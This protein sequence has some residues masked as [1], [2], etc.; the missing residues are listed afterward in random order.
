[1]EEEVENVRVSPLASI[2]KKTKGE[3]TKE[4]SDD[5]GGLATER[6]SQH[7]TLGELRSFLFDQEDGCPADADL[8]RHIA[9][10]SECDTRI[11]HL[12]AVERYRRERTPTA[13]E[14]SAK[15]KY[16]HTETASPLRILKPV[17]FTAGAPPQ[18]QPISRVTSSPQS[19]EIAELQFESERFTN[20]L[21]QLLAS[22]PVWDTL[23]QWNDEIRTDELDANERARRVADVART[24]ERQLRR[25][26][27]TLREGIEATAA[28]LFN[29]MSAVSVT[30]AVQEQRIRSLVHSLSSEEQ[31]AFLVYMMG[32]EWFLHAQGESLWYTELLGGLERRIVLRMDLLKRVLMSAPE[33]PAVHRD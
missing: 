26:D 31:R 29:E 1:M 8:A 25:I 11:A 23:L 21:A 30:G 2:R 10:C 16:V 4:Q 6:C 7:N 22:P 9:E 12:R 28:Q 27:P 14:F 32:Q 33:R 18:P 20:N 19:I 3:H 5:V 17:P 24:C 13:G 15:R